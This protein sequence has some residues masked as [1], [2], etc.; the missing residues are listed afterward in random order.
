MA[1]LDITKDEMNKRI[2]RYEKAHWHP[3]AFIDAVLPQF[4]RDVFSIIGRGVKDD[5]SIP[6]QISAYDGFGMTIIKCGPQ[7][8]TGLHDHTTSEV[9]IALTGKWT[10]QWGDEGE[11]E[12]ILNQ[13]DAVS[14][15]AGVMRGFRNESDETALIMGM[16]SGSNPDR[17]IWSKRVMEAVREKGFDFDADGKIARITKS[18]VGA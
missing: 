3:R 10:V 11:N 14:V 1:K 18:K 4:E 7:K 15:P 5:N 9:F 16:V 13:F 8:G 17:I 12:F 2:S 6:P